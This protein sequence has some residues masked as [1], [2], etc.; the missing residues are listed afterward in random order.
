MN[1][2]KGK[3]KEIQSTRGIAILAVV[4]IHITS[5]PLEVLP[6][7]V[8]SH[9]VYTGINRAL[10][11]AVPLFLMVSA[12]V[13]AYGIGTD[14]AI[15]WRDFYRKRWIRVV[16]PFMVWTT[17]Y[18]SLLF[19]T[20]HVGK[21]PTLKELLLWY[22]FGKGFYH[23][24]FLSVVIQFYLVFPFLHVFWYRYRPSL[25]N[26]IIILATLQVAF[27]W[28]NRMYLYPHF[29]YTASLLPS[30][31]FPIGV[32]L[33]LG[34]N[35]SAWN[36]LW[37]R[38]RVLIG[39]FAILSGSFYVQQYLAVLAGHRINT[40]YFQMVWLLYATTIGICII[41][42]SRLLQ[43]GACGKS[44]I[45]GKIGELSFG[46]YLVHPFF[47]ML[48]QRVFSPVTANE[49]HLF[50][51]LGLVIILTLSGLVTYGLERT[52]LAKPLYGI[53]RR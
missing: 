15:K 16:V 2:N 30:Y 24:Y 34:Y 10:Q 27:Y 9:T 4:L 18:L 36:H 29:P 6:A 22:G 43:Q 7:G 20:G 33:W 12:L 8:P 50:T 40:F 17:L 14:G 31:I 46:I 25:V 45:I 1:N 53:I 41:F 44:A 35:V 19:I 32:G 26:T 47:L 38:Y 21:V 28:I 5:I 48:W 13:L 49:V 11:F 39:I 42:L 52:I 3:L 37:T 23:L 51:C